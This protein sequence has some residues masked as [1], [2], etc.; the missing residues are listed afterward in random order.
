MNRDAF[1]TCVGRVLGPALDNLPAH[2]GEKVTN[3]IEARGSQVAQ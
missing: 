1:E 3:L 2:K